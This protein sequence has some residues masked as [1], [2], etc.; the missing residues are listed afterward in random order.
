MRKALALLLI[1]LSICP[2]AIAVEKVHQTDICVY[3]GTASGIA[4]ALAA[5]QRG[6]SVIV[7]EPFGHLGGIAGG[8][9][10]IKQDCLYYDDIGGIAKELHDAD[11]ALGGSN[12]MNQ[13]KIRLMLKKKCDDA[14]I[15][16][17]TE[18][19][20]DSSDDV[21]KNGATIE[22]I[23]L[24]YA[25]VM[26]EGVPTPKPDKKKALAV[27]ASVFI[28]ASYEGDLMAFAKSDYATGREA[29]S[30]YNESLGGQR[31]LKYFDVDP[32]VVPG[33]PK[34]GVLPM[35]TTEPYEPGSASTYMIA[36]NFRLQWVSR[37][38]TPIKTLGRDVDRK[39]YALAIRALA[40][41][42]E[43]K[44]YVHWPHNNYARASMISSGRRMP[45][46]SS[47]SFETRNLSIGNG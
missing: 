44:R 26:D 17:F 25:P 34:S 36:Y 40:K 37:D 4:A 2:P 10:R 22:N 28:D 30:K 46:S 19:R 3:G 32:Y 6:Q 14:G 42:G 31:G 13:W 24:N 11:M 8:G 33:D 47:M 21:V 1:A 41:Y 27:K 29:R 9:I 43:N 39:K 7:I 16:Y 5:R 15:K 35:I 23:H 45:P 18:Y 38:G 12:H 20:L